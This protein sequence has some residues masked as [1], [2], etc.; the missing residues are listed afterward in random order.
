MKRII[1][2][3]CLLLMIVQLLPVSA[4]ATTGMAHDSGSATISVT[5]SFDA[6]ALRAVL[7]EGFQNCNTKIDISAF[8]ISSTSENLQ[9]I[10]GIIDE[11]LPECF[12]VSNV[13]LWSQLDK[14]ITVEASYLAT[15][16]EYEVMLANLISTKNKLLQGIKGNNSLG[17]VEKALLI[18]DRLALMCEYDYN[19]TSHR[20]DI[21][22]ALVNGAAVC[23]GYAVA[24]DYLL[25][26]VGIPGYI[27]TSKQLNH[28]WNIIYINNTPYHV[29]VTWDD[30]AWSSGSRGAEG[31]V[32]HDNFLRSSQGIFESG[33]NAYDYDTSPSDTTYD[34]YFWRT[35]KTAFELIDNDLYYIDNE[36]KKLKRYSDGEQLCSVAGYWPYQNLGYWSNQARLS[37]DGTNLY[38]SLADAVY[39]YDVATGKS[40]K[41]LQLQLDNYTSIYGFTYSDGKLICDINDSPPYSGS[42]S[43]LCQIRHVYPVMA[44]VDKWNVALSDD[45]DT[46]FYL[47]IDDSVA[48]TAEVKISVGQKSVTKRVADL[49]QKEGL[50]KV[51]VDVAAAQMNERISVQVLNGKEEIYASEYTVRRYCLAILKDRSQSKYRSLVKQM[52]NYGAMAQLFFGYGTG[53]LANAGIDADSFELPEDVEQLSLSGKINGINFYGASLVYQERI[54]VR[55]Y[56]TGDVTGLKFTANGNIYTPVAKDGMHY[57]EI[58]DILPQNLDQQ[59]TLVAT[60]ANG[61]SLSVTYGPMNYIVRMNRKG[62]ETTQNLMKALYNYYLAAKALTDE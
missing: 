3:L 54:A 47:A 9:L 1:A 30:I 50:Y 51:S 22:G 5:D 41:I 24:Y 39:Q 29:D 20:H 17:D 53:E 38:Y 10:F 15:K 18:H 58:A 11:Q 28:A 13:V 21:Y 46:K 4:M 12:H 60:D 49:E 42:L 37:G 57:I 40:N 61:S 16:S 45:F 23:Q 44:T 8:E 55:Y 43:L 26:E 6:D 2:I 25:E 27:C 31:A 48:A 19:K 34:N 33:H 36:A 32:K 7:L 14:F 62:D 59:I 52:L 35:S 56:F